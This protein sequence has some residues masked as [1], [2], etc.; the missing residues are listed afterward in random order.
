MLAV[1]C[2]GVDVAGEAAEREVAVLVSSQAHACA[3][4]DDAVVDSF[5]V[6]IHGR[7]NERVVHDVSVHAE[8]GERS[9]RKER[10]AREEHKGICLHFQSWIA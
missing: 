9:W 8:A 3:A 2:D 1:L 4:N 7:T 6:G 10:N 5:G